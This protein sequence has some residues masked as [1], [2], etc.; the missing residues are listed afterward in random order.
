MGSNGRRSTCRRDINEL[1]TFAANDQAA[2]RS[3]GQESV[4][5]HATRYLQIRLEMIDHPYFQGQ[6]FPIGSGSVESG[7]KV[8]V[9]RW[10]KG[11]GMRWAE[12][13]VDPMLALRDLVCNHRWQEGWS[14]IVAHQQRQRRRKRSSEGYL[15]RRTQPNQLPLRN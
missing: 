7:H 2:H 15:N 14:E 8:V 9:Q 1:N 5:D 6:G 3:R 4:L 13:H 11:A 12:H 10:L